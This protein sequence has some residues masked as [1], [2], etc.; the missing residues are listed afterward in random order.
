MKDEDFWR[1]SARSARFHV[2][3]DNEKTSV[4][5]QNGEIAL[6]RLDTDTYHSTKAELEHFY[7]KLVQGGVLIIDDY[8]HALGARRATNEYLSDPTRRIMLH[9]VNFTNRIGIKL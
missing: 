4:N 7:P 8:G 2:K 3:G 1:R 9:R 6:L 5:N